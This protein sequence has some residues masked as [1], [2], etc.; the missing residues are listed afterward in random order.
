MMVNIG[1]AQLQLG[2]SP[3]NALA[4]NRLGDLESDN[5]RND[6][7]A[8]RFARAC[9]LDP[10]NSAYHA[11]AE[12]AYL[13]QKMY[14]KAIS[15]LGRAVDLFPEQ[16]LIFYNLA[17]ALFAVGKEEAAVK[18]LAEAVRIDKGYARG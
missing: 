9:E 4:H 6:K 5:G 17:V 16:P 1:N 13:Q 18:E 14:D 12:T 3:Q 7:A 8:E 11:S 10:E 15:Y 2:D